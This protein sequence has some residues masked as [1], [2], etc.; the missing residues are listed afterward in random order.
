MKSTVSKT[1]KEIEENKLWEHWSKKKTFLLYEGI[2]LERGSIP[3]KS[4]DESSRAEI[5][6]RHT[7]VLMDE[8]NDYD[9]L[10]ASL[11]ADESHGKE[12]SE[13]G[14]EQALYKRIERDIFY[15]HWHGCNLPSRNKFPN[16]KPKYE[17]GIHPTERENMLKMIIAMAIKGYSYSP[18]KQRNDAVKE[19]EKDMED[20]QIPL[21]DDTIRKFLNE[22]KELLPPLENT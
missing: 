5:I 22:A 14:N 6:R 4:F 17:G 21:G 16:I 10:Y 15:K 12:W 3:P 1:E 20:L 9:L 13:Y 11:C 2:W 18:K 19:L 7:D 8:D